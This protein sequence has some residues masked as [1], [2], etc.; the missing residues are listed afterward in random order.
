MSSQAGCAKSQKG[1]KNLLLREVSLSLPMSPH[2][3]RV[4]GANELDCSV[5][6]KRHLGRCWM[7]LEI[8]YGCGKRG[9]KKNKCPRLGTPILACLV[10]GKEYLTTCCEYA[11]Q[12]VW[13]GRSGQFQG[14]AQQ[15]NTGIG[16]PALEAWR[17]DK[18]E[19]YNVCKNGE[20]QVNGASQFSGPR[21]RYMKCGKCHPGVCRYGTNVCY[22]CG[23]SGHLQ[24]YCHLSRQIMGRGVAQPASSTATSS[25]A[26]SGHGAVGGS[27]QSSRGP[28][29]F[30]AIKRH[31]RSEAFP[32]MVT[33][34]LTFQYRGV[35]ALIDSGFALS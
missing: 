9:N 3:Q 28:N 1:W 27:I 35:Y 17:K 19:I 22:K 29:R 5:C 8:C 26:P 33:G 11:Q 34:I 12:R 25:I 24:R 21:P 14:T 2:H 10:F 32:G 13:G 16:T 15:T 6:K 20:Y 30:Y 4:V 7:T 18:G 31:Q 23:M